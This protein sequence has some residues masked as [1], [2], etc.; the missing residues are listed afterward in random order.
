M[1]LLSKSC[2]FACLVYFWLEYALFC[3]SFPFLSKLCFSLTWSASFKNT[4]FSNFLHVTLPL[5]RICHIQLLFSFLLKLCPSAYL[6]YFS[7]KMPYLAIFICSYFFPA[8]V[9][10]IMSYSPPLL[11]LPLLYVFDPLILSR[12]IFSY[13]F[14]F[15]T[16]LCFSVDLVYFCPEYTIPSHFLIFLSKLSFLCTWS[17]PGQNMPFLSKL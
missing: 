7:K 2:F 1:P 4:T 10:Q 13:S 8:T 5:P 3:H 12:Y 14:L 9:V 15:L 6:V 16:K 11:F 17:A